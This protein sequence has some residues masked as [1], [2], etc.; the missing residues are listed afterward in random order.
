MRPT[1]IALHGYTMNGA[2]LRSLGEELFRELEQHVE[3]VFPDAPHVCTPEAAQEAFS[4]WGIAP[5]APPYLRWWRASDGGEVYEGWE[6]A[7]ASVRALIPE[8]GP[9]GVLGF[10]QGAML[11]A[12][13]AALSDRRRFPALRCAVLIAGGL[14]RARDLSEL[15]SAPLAVPSL[16]V[17]GERDPI[18]GRSAPDLAECFEQAQRETATW[19]GSHAI[20]QHVPA[21]TT[22]VRFVQERL[23]IE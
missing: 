8:G 13:L 2:R 7:C 16:H 12:T 4:A 14:P 10:S 5:P 19:P 20:P 21:A 18:A 1:L 6:A 17:W 3:L 9:V 23:G 11:A 22:I 15:F